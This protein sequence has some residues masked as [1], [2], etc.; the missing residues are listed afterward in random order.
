MNA[1]GTIPARE[2]EGHQLQTIPDGI[3]VI[4]ELA[5]NTRSSNGSAALHNRVLVM[6]EI[7]DCAFVNFRPFPAGKCAE[8]AAASGFWI[9]LARVQ[10][11]LA[12]F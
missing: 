2:F 10:A 9:L 5:S 11:V 7:L 4:K 12:G 6:L 1:L 8:V 3:T